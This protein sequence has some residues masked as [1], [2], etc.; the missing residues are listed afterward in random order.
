MQQSIEKV[1]KKSTR[2]R[3]TAYP[4]I[5]L[6]QA[7][8]FSAKLDKAFGNSQFNREDAVVQMGY[9]TVTGTSGTRISALVHYG[10]LNREGKA[11]RNSQLSIR[12]AHPIDDDYNQA[13]KQACLAPKLFSSLIK[14]YAGK[15]VP[16][17]LSSILIQHHGIARRVSAEVARIF[18]ETIKF[19]DLYPND[20]VSVELIGLID[21][22]E[23]KNHEVQNPEVPPLKVVQN[24]PKSIINDV[25]LASDLESIP[26]PSGA[27]LW[28]PKQLAYGIAM[29]KFA[30]VI[31]A[32]DAEISNELKNNKTDHGHETEHSSPK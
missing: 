25:K 12:L 2:D 19:A 22:D 24:P 27:I 18:L 21:E 1:A 32:L 3:S 7:V 30:G 14:E 15:A 4:A 31:S 23:K 10:L 9:K 11:Y 17:A 28:Y 6:E 29:G 16:T 20:K 8:A 13:I 5:P 26:L